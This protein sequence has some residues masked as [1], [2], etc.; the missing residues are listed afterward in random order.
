ML[1]VLD[2]RGSQLSAAELATRLPRA[3][4]STAAALEAVAPVLADVRERGAAALREA[5]ERF[6]G[7]RPTDLRVPPTA[8]QAALADLDPQVRSALELASAHAQAG[9]AAQVPPAA[10]TQIVPGGQVRQR[11]I[12]VRRVGLYAPGGLA[13]YPSS[14]VMNVAAAR[15]A[16]VEQIALASP[17]QAAHGGLVHPTIMAACA[18]LGVDEVYAVGGAQAIAMFAYGA[19][20]ATPA[21]EAVAREGWLCAPVDV[22]TG[23]GNA[24]VAAAKRAVRGTVGIDAEAGPTEIAILADATAD[25][26]YVAADLISQAEHDPA[27]A[28]VL[29]TDSAAL[30]ER[31]RQEVAAQVE[32]TQ[33]RERVTTALAGPQSG[34]VLVDDLDAM[35]ATANAYAAEHLEIHTANASAV[36]ERIRNAG[37]IFVGPYTPVPLGDYVAGSNHVLPTGGTAR[38]DAGL[39]V[40]AYLKPVQVVEYTRAALAQLTEPLTALALAEDLPAHAFAAQVRAQ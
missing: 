8:L 4:L 6:D 21:D 20:P 35:V 26:R 27:A 30:G 2:L 31:V 39:S 10:V 23:P 1:D 14:V 25:A 15:A 22:V 7:V 29:I 11:W 38:F 5:A 9:H 28:A 18:L 12:A 33:H 40:L 32:R 24:Y 34:I 17:P 19:R 37:A 13:V 3:A 16:G 36:A